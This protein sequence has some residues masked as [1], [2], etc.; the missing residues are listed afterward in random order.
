MALDMRKNQEALLKAYNEVVS[1][2]SDVDWL[3]FGYEG[4]STTLKLVGKGEGGIEEMAEELS[5]SKVMYAYCRVLDP[6]TNLPKYVLIN[7]QGEG[8]PDSMKFKCANHLHDVKA[9]LRSIHVTINARDDVDINA[10]DITK[11][12]ASASGANYSIH[13]EERKPVKKENKFANEPAGPVGS[14]YKRTIA[15]KD[16]S[17]KKRDDFWAKTEQE[18]KQRQEEE[19]RKA[20]EKQKEFE[21]ERREREEKEAKERERLIQERAKQASQMKIA[22]RRANSIDKEQKKKQWEARALGSS[23]A[24]NARALFKRRESETDDNDISRRPPPPARSGFGSQSSQ[25]DTQEND[26]RS[27]PLARKP[28]PPR[29]PSPP[30]REPSPPRR[31]PSPPPRQ[32][33]PPPREPSPPPRQPSPEPVS[34]NEEPPKLPKGRNLLAEGLPRRQDSDEEEDSEDW[35]DNETSPPVIQAVHATPSEP[36]EEPEQEHEEIAQPDDMPDLLP[37]HG[38]SD[39]SELTFDPGDIIT[40]IEQID[41][42]W[43]TGYTADGHSGMFPS[44]YVELLNG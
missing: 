30:A 43:W 2:K 4:Q 16:I 25:D 11:K 17:S 35:D 41:E 29:E 1:D 32:P 39:Q 21:K 23:S 36:I 10:D 40:N 19:K 22:E 26:R 38:L 20:T 13:N 34:R 12:V 6:N 42:G 3:V 7:W 33:S 44:N 24:A 14:V 18:E 27:P 28:S 15:A 31:E 9:F 8:A 5:G 37:E